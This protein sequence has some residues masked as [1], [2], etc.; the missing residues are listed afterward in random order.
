MSAARWTD[1][2]PAGAVIPVSKK[3]SALSGPS[4]TISRMI[5][6]FSGNDYDLGELSLEGPSI[7]PP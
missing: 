5:K 1:R 7:Q 2:N 4:R 6:A 3:D